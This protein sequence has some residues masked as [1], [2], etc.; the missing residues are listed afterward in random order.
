ML[1]LRDVSFT[2][3]E[4]DALRDVSVSF[5][6]NQLI[7][8]A[9]PNGSGKSTM[10]KLAA[11]VASPARGEVAYDGRPL[12]D[13]PAKEY[14]KQVG[15]LPQDAEPAFPMRAIDVV[16]SGRAPFL[17]R[18]AWEGERDFAEARRAL[19]L[20]DATHL[21]ERYFDE[22]SGGERKR[23]FLARVLAGTPRVILLDEPFAALDVAAA[24]LLDEQV[25]AHVARGGAVVYTTHQAAGIDAAARVIEL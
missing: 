4:N 19:E 12:R 6:A 13:W 2:Y 22:M 18:F 25:R 3:G 15:Y 1:E 20:V 9:G 5:G 7:A 16:V 24:A 23:I 11:R 10:L 14:A 17:G 8:L 21:A